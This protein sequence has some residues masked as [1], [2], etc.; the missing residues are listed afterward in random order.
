MIVVFLES[1][2][3]C[4]G[5]DKEQLQ[6]YK[7]CTRYSEVDKPCQVKSNDG[8]LARKM[9]VKTNEWPNITELP[10]SPLIPHKQRDIESDQ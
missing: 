2:G 10:K 3:Q 5:H 8:H 4:I 9:I 6:K 7:G 1:P